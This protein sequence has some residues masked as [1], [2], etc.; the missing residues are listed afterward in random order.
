M[1][2]LSEC[3]SITLPVD[4]SN[5]ATCYIPDTCTSIDCC[6]EVATLGRSFRTYVDIDTCSYKLTVEIDKIHLEYS[7]VDYEWGKKETYTL[8]GLLN[9]E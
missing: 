1:C 3:Q 7:L 8:F 4:I 9:L 2:Y 5:S 6:I